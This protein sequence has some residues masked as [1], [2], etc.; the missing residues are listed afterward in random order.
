MTGYYR[1]DLG[2]IPSDPVYDRLTPNATNVSWQDVGLFQTKYEPIVSRFE[3][4]V[5]TWTKETID[6]S[7]ISD[8]ISHPAY[9]EIIGMGPRAV[10][11]LLNELRERPD[12]WFVALEAITGED[13][14][15]DDSSGDLM[16]MAKAWLEWGDREGYYD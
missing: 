10:P 7:S 8:I 13:P 4:L 5:D 15:S 2:S 6:I 3:E 14:T 12:F 1:F 11:L 16:E 9:L